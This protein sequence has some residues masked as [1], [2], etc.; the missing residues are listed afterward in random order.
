MLVYDRHTFFYVI[1]LCHDFFI[2]SS[3]KSFIIL[4]DSSLFKEISC[5]PCVNSVSFVM[6][7]YFSL[8]YYKL[9][10][11]EIWYT[12]VN[13]F[14]V[15]VDFLQYYTYKQILYTS[16]ALTFATHLTEKYSVH[17]G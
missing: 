9:C 14:C 17:Y 10:W 6:L 15:F 11:H 12:S 7:R 3:P 8:N 2:F 5:K 13:V 1:A 4:L 16:R